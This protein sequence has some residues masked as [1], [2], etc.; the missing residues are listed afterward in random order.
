MKDPVDCT[1]APRG[2]HFVDA[3]ADALIHFTYAQ[4]VMAPSLGTVGH[5]PLRIHSWPATSRL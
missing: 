3:T 5:F 4:K 2:Q 1:D